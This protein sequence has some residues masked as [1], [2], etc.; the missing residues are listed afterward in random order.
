M[1][2]RMVFILD[3]SDQ[4]SPVFRRIGESADRFHR[5]INDAVDASGGEMRAYTRDASGN[6][7]ELAGSMAAA[8]R[9]AEAMGAQ[10]AEAAPDVRAIGDAADESNEAVTR[11]TRDSNGRLRDL[12]GRYVSAAAAA[13]ELARASG[14][15]APEVTAVGS[16]AD[17]TAARTRTLTIDTD[18]AAPSIRRVGTAAASTAADVGGKGGGLTGALWAAA[19]VAGFTLLPALGA[20]VPMLAGAGVAAGTLGLGFSGIG[21]AMEAAGK[22]KKEFAEALKG[23]TP[24]A[25]DFTKQLVSTKKEFEGLGDRIQAVML[26][27]FTKALKEADPVIRI[28]GDSMVKMGGSFGNAAAGVGRL[29]KDSGFQQDFTRVLQLGG[30]FVKDLTSGLGGLSRG[31]LSFGA[32]SGPTLTALSGG[33]RDL[34]ARGLPGMFKGLETGV[35][36]SGKFLTGLFSM[37]NSL[38]PALGRLSGEFSRTFGPILG[39]TLAGAGKALSGLFDAISFGVRL[40]RPVIDDLHYGLKSIGLMVDYL[41][42][43]FIGAGRAIAGAFLPATAGI[44]GVKGP[45]QRLHAL[46]MENKLGLMEFGRRGADAIVGF[47]QAGVAALPTLMSGFRILSIWALGA[48]DA[49]LGGATKAFGWIPGVG[50]KLRT[51]SSEFDQFKG[52]FISGLASAEA[53]TASFSATVGPRLARNRLEMNISAWQSQIAQANRDLRTVPPEKRAALLAN[54]RDLENKVAQAKRDLRSIPDE[55]VYIRVLRVMQT[56]MPF[57]GY[58][59]GFATG[60]LIRGPGT[61]TSDSIPHMLSNGEFVVRASSVARF[62]VPFL[63]ALNEGRL[64]AIG[65]QTTTP[66]AAGAVLSGGGGVTF[67]PQITVQ[68]A[69]DP[70]AVGQQLRRM[71]LELQRTYGLDTGVIMR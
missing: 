52:K 18:R 69:L 33:L 17:T 2:E 28:V 49:I 4:L 14:D 13:A 47:V 40:A 58:M 16:A 51:A 44:E 31:F 41:K 27:G 64:P 30:V 21:E 38:L 42:P 34:L 60:G 53:M 50:D 56:I 23:L 62:G 8:G 43:A 37:I 57:A 10:A 48:M 55:T 20:L 1:A 61:S 29:M 71:L 59:P 54:K 67:A 19:G 9:A 32:A 66:V 22:G 39:T 65:S 11:F 45:L 15:A 3:G 5:R 26:P 68:G 24:Q 12:R 25:R 63:E 46:V 35:E 6:L 7:T 70:V 36:G